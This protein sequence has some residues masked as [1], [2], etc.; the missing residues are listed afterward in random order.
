MGLEIETFKRRDRQAAVAEYVRE[1]PN[2]KRWVDWLQTKRV[3][4]NMMT[5]PQ[6]LAWLDT[7]MTEHDSVKVVPPD[8]VLSTTAHEQL[9]KHMRRIITERILKDAGADK[10][11]ADAVR[12]MSLPEG[13][14]FAKGLWE[15]LSEH[16]DANWR[17]YVEKIAADLAD[18]SI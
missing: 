8:E 15:W 17:D 12:S 4:L 16:P 5:T 9:T 11:I 6:F 3:E 7:K 18:R 14:D 13:K 1:R 10:Q 2:G